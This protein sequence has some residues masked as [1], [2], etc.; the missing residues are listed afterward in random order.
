MIS[1]VW[2][3]N[4][5]NP[6]RK[7]TGF[8]VLGAEIRRNFLPHVFNLHPGIDRN[9]APSPLKGKRGWALSVW[10]QNI[11]QMDC[12]KW[13]WSGFAGRP[14]VPYCFRAYRQLDNKGISEN[15][16]IAAPKGKITGMVRRYNIGI[17]NGQA[18]ECDAHECSCSFHARSA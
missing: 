2:L 6:R 7:Q 1:S 9:Q 15:R 4:F 16:L 5:P 8:N 13:E 18:A 12:G 10:P 14:H 17:M 11:R 3:A